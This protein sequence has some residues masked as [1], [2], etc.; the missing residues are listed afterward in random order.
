MSTVPLSDFYCLASVHNIEVRKHYTHSSGAIRVWY[1]TFLQYKQTVL[2]QLMKIETNSKIIS[3]RLLCQL[4]RLLIISF[5]QINLPTK[6]HTRPTTQRQ[7]PNLPNQSRARL[8]P[9]ATNSKTTLAAFV[10]SPGSFPSI[11]YFSITS[12]IEAAGVPLYGSEMGTMLDEP[13]MFVLKKVGSTMRIE[14]LNG[15]SSAAR[16]SERPRRGAFSKRSQICQ[17]KPLPSRACFEA[18]YKEPPGKG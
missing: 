3:I 18:E 17:I 7:P 15:A 16:A 1:W 2:V 13:R 8:L 5:Q 10:G 14:I 12:I 9:P 4:F 11:R 6:H